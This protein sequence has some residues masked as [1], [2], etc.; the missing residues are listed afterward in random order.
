MARKFNCDE[1]KSLIRRVEELSV[2]S[3][4]DT[5]RLQCRQVVGRYMAT[6]P[7]GK[8]PKRQVEFF[9]AQLEYEYEDGRISALEMIQSIIDFFSQV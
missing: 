3:Q 9:C 6:Y 7:E 5:V 2:V 1:I 4:I 8:R